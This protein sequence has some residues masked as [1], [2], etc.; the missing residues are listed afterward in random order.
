MGKKYEHK[1]ANRRWA[2]RVTDFQLTASYEEFLGIGTEPIEFEWNSIPGLTS[3]GILQEIQKDLQERNIEPVILEIEL[4]SCQCSMISIGHEKE[5]KRFVFRIH[6]KSRCTRRDSRRDIGRS[7][8]L[9]RTR[10]CMEDASTNLKE[11]K[12]PFSQMANR[13][14]ETGHPIF[15]SASAFSREILRKLKG[16]ETIHF[17]ADSSNTELLFLHCANQPSTYGSS[18]KMV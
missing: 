6:K 16:K 17:N 7:S 10:S 5:T 14:K 15:T 18:F 12:I 2:G 13:F 4:F 9:E 1:K 11:N 8:V 3:L